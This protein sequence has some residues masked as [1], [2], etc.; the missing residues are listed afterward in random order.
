M[1]LKL[2][3]LAQVRALDRIVVS[4]NDDGVVQ[5]ANELAEELPL[6]LDVVRR[7]DRY[8][9]ATTS[10]ESF[11]R[12]YVSTLDVSGTML[13]A[14]V[15]HPL[16][17]GEAYERV[18]RM[19]RGLDRKRFDSVVTTTRLQEFVWKDGLPFNYDP[20]PER[21]PRSQDLHPLQIINHAAY[22]LDFDTL[23][24]LGDRMGQRPRFAELKGHEA[25][26]IDWPEDFDLADEIVSARRGL[27]SDS[28]RTVL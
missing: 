19:W 20:V 1:E 15:T 25:M 24:L 2:R 28:A 23:Q 27:V 21:W 6:R 16:M 22:V 14:H 3:Q 17:T 8:G 12:D 7:P 5:I 11:I 4:S 18:L 26:D 9:R 10:M 13:W